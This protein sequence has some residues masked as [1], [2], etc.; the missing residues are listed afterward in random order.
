MDSRTAPIPDNR[1]LSGQERR[2][3]HWMLVHGTPEA[4]AFLTQLDRAHVTARC[5]C[6]CASVDFGV[7]GEPGPTGAMR[8]LGDYLFGAPGALCGCFIFEQSGVLGGI[9]VWG[10]DVPNPV[11]L[12]EP[13]ELRLF[14]RGA[15]PKAE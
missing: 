11:A 7:D 13:E 5:P 6:E 2:L 12:P 3:A 9:E 8:V 4:A 1:P 10:L 15:I 14:E